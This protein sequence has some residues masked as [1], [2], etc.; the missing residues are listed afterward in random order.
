MGAHYLREWGPGVNE[1]L[2][3]TQR[4]GLLEQK[5]TG[6][7]HVEVVYPHPVCNSWSQRAPQDIQGSHSLQAGI[8]K[9]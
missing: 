4:K 8:Y 2:E 3:S 1:K 6:R 5:Q 9:A 7:S